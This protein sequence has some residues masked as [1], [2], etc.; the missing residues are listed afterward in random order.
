MFKLILVIFAL[1]IAVPALA[2]AP[3]PPATCEDNLKIVVQYSQ[4]ANSE[5]GALKVQNASLKV[6]IGDKDRRIA[7]LEK[8]AAAAKAPAKTEAKAPEVKK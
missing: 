4:D 2:Q 6:Q 7:D 1:I 8:A 5:N 3:Q